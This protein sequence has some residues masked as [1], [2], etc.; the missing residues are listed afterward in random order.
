MGQRKY[1]VRIVGA[2]EQTIEGYD[3]AH[4]LEQFG[5]E[6]SGGYDDFWSQDTDTLVLRLET[7]NEQDTWVQAKLA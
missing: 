5:S 7:L 6:L 2:R 4:V 3:L 1:I